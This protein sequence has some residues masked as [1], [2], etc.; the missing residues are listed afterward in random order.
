ME[1][2]VIQTDSLVPIINSRGRGEA[3]AGSLGRIL[4]IPPAAWQ[5][6][7]LAGIIIEIVLR[8]PMKRRIV[9]GSKNPLLRDM[10]KPDF[11]II[12]GDMVGD[13]VYQ[14]LKAGG[15]DPI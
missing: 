5:V 14:N 9:G 11:T 12:P 8:S 4:I 13:K 3:V 10:T 7:T 2:T 6:K 1:V 15:M